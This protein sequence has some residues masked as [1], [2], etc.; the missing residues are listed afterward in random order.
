MKIIFLSSPEFGIPSLEKLA[1]ENEILA[2]ITQPDSEQGRGHKVLPCPVA[3]YAKKN[4]FKL[5]Q[6]EKISRDGVE[7][8]T[9]LAPDIM[10]TCAYGQI[11]SQE[12]IDIPKFGI[13]NVHASLL[14]KYRGAS[15]IQ[16]A[17][18]NGEVETGITIMQTEIG[19]D[20]G[21]IIK[22]VKTAIYPDETAGELSA[23]LSYIGADMVTEAVREIAAGAATFTKQSFNDATVTK[24]LTKVNSTI[25]F[26]KTAQQI[27]NVVRGSNP[28]P[29]ARTELNNEQIKI[30]KTKVRGDLFSTEPAGTIIEPTSGKNGLFVACG[31]GVLEIVELGFPNGKII[32]GRE[33]VGSRKISIGQRFSSFT[34]AMTD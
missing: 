7:T 15:P 28:D 29:I 2:V 4:N 1:K 16:T 20:T 6:F 3:D 23:R 25:N 30:F 13:I 31:M 14:P 32:T 12:V 21:D 22:Q 17:I 26:E 27:H 8:L 33:A 9:K 5:Y 24:K 11:L 34:E 18:I 10:V 19:L